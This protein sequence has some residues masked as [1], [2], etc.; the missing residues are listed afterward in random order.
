MK[1]KVTVVICALVAVSAI[2]LAQSN[3]PQ[4]ILSILLKTEQQKQ[5]GLHK[6]S[7]AERN[8]L[9]SIF[10]LILRSQSLGDSA[11]KYLKNEGWEEVKVLGTR[12]LKVDEWSDAKEY[13]IVAK[14]VWTYILESKTFSSLRPGTYLGKMG[15]TSCEIIDSDGDTVRFWTKDKR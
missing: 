1:T 14:G 2:A 4:D 10:S 11:V 15:L 6:L 12:R 7:Q 13:L 9:G 3:A 5:C 8:S